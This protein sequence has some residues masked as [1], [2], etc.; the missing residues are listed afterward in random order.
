MYE[1]PPL[2]YSIE[3]VPSSQ[4]ESYNLRVA[5]KA[6]TIVKSAIQNYIDSF[7]S[8]TG[9]N[10]GYITSLSSPQ[11]MQYVTEL[12]Y[13]E[14]MKTSPNLKKTYLA[15]FFAENPG[16]VPS[17]L[18]I[19]QGQDYVD[20]GISELVGATLDYQEPRMW[21]GIFQF[22]CRV[23]LSINVT[24]LSEENTEDITTLLMLMFGPLADAVNNHI[25]NSEDSS[26]EVRIPLI[27]FSASGLTNIPIEGDTKTQVWSRAIDMAF[28]FETSL[29]LKEPTLKFAPP[30]TTLIGNTEVII[31]R[32]LNLSPNQNIQLGYPYTLLI[33]NM[34]FD[35]TLGTSDPNIA[36]VT[37]TP[38]YIL[39]PRRQGKCL[40]LVYSTANKT[41]DIPF[42][43]QPS[44]NL[45]MDV[46][47]NV[48][49]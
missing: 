49:I 24:T 41:V 45:L 4:K 8:P 25:I 28:E 30:L 33:E 23:S 1:N 43:N 27:P 3:E 13:D 7:L 40:L 47:F 22:V 9:V 18:L 44:K 10:R 32:F 15:K 36:L 21:V 16:K 14:E 29:Y 31:P 11:G 6:V 20:T 26:W 34:T 17:I 37:S 38:P 46:P 5:D 12:T 42:E 35:Y 48:T 2:G 39:Q 19:D